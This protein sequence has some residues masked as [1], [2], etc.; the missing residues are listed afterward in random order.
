MEMQLDERAGPRRTMLDLGRKLGRSRLWTLRSDQP[1][2]NCLTAGK[3]VAATITRQGAEEGQ[4]ESIDVTLRPSSDNRAIHLIAHSLGAAWVPICM[5]VGRI[6]NWSPFE[7]A[8]VEEKV[9]QTTNLDAKDR[10][11]S[12]EKAEQSIEAMGSL[13]ADDEGFHL[14]THASEEQ[15]ALPFSSPDLR[16]FYHRS[17][18][19]IEVK[20]WLPEDREVHRGVAELSYRGATG[21]VRQRRSLA[22]KVRVRDHWKASA[23]L[24]PPVSSEDGKL[25]IHVRPFTDDDL[26]L[27]PPRDV[28]DVLA[29]RMCASMPLEQEADGFVF[30]PSMDH[31]RQAMEDPDACWCLRVAPAGKEGGDDA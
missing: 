4:D 24:R 16:C 31:H 23:H 20:A 11:G 8:S 14:Y 21:V 9:Q 6:D 22:F 12:S 29:S 10:R 28:Q 13:A 2:A 7:A 27:L 26:D 15:D 1:L 3:S 19:L 5:V 25:R 17:E 18:A 30:R